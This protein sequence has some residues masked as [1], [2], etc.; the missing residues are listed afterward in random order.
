MKQIMDIAKPGTLKDSSAAT[1]RPV[2][3]SNRVIVQDP[4]VTADTSAETTK[5][6][7]EA[8]ATKPDKVVIKP[9]SDPSEETAKNEGLL[10]ISMQGDSD[11]DGDGVIEAEEQPQ[12]L[13]P[14]PLPASLSESVPASESR[15]KESIA[16][17][18][19]AADLK[20]EEELTELIDSKEYNLPIQ[21]AENR[22]TRLVT[23][24]GIILILV[25]AAAWANMALDA[26]F[27][28]IPGV[29]PLT[30]FFNTP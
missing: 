8:P 20:S 19:D 27:I 7:P 1:A 15:S 29:Q 9:L 25:L 30:H 17:A 4:M 14:S 12:P 13:P 26:G 16:T 5:A 10:T 6:A 22:R 3:V 24:F 11:T 21:T 2:I 28:T 18:K 23:I